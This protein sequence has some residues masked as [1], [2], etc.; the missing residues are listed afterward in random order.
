MTLEVFAH[1]VHEAFQAEFKDALTGCICLD[2]HLTLVHKQTYFRLLSLP[3]KRSWID[4]AVKLLKF[5]VYS[6]WEVF[7]NFDGSDTNWGVGF[8][9]YYKLGLWS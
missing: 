5:D 7:G 9:R 6:C 8:G 1:A 4:L 3:G 2:N